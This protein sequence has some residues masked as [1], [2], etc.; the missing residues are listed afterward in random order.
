MILGKKH[1]LKTLSTN[2]SS[3]R[4]DSSCSCRPGQ[5]QVSEKY[6]L[7]TAQNTQAETQTLHA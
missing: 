3:D 1:L 4:S 6:H 2:N 7:G 5:W